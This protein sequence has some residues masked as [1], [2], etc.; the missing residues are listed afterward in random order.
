MSVYEITVASGGAVVL[1]LIVATLFLATR[2]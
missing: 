1:Y 2:Q